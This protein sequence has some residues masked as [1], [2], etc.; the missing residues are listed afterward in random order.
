M[1]AQRRSQAASRH[2]RRFIDPGPSEGEAADDPRSGEMVGADRADRRISRVQHPVLLRGSRL[3]R[4]LRASL[5]YQA[6][7]IDELANKGGTEVGNAKETKALV[8]RHEAALRAKELKEADDAHKQAW[9]LWLFVTF[10]IGAVLTIVGKAASVR[11]C[12]SEECSCGTQRVSRVAAGEAVVIDRSERLDRDVVGGL[13]EPHPVWL[14]GF[15]M[16]Y[17]VLQSAVDEELL[18]VTGRL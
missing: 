17:G 12:V 4:R 5:D 3:L 10:I 2:R 15:S 9:R 7:Q 18:Q 13:A 16:R 8:E 1:V 14:R 11:Y 6:V